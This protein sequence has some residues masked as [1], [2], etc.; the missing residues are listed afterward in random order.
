ME[1]KIEEYIIDAKD[2]WGRV[3]KSK[4]QRRCRE[5]ED[6]KI[7]QGK[8]VKVDEF[9]IKLCSCGGVAQYRVVK[10]YNKPR[11][12]IWCTKCMAVIIKRHSLKDAIKAWNERIL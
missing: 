4:L 11:E 2:F 8:G 6:I 7:A 9:V 1:T 3:D 10:S 5:K 12:H